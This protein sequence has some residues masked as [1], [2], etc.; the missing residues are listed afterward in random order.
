MRKV[1]VLIIPVA[2]VGFATGQLTWT[3]V[4]T[5]GFGDVNNII[6]H[7]M[8]VYDGNLYTGTENWITGTE[9]WRYKNTTWTQVNA[10]GFGDV[11]NVGTDSMAVYYGDLYAGIRNWTTGI[12]VW[13]YNGRG[14][15]R[16]SLSSPV[17]G[18]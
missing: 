15:P 4:N 13:K 18:W 8:A 16:M 7:S 12:E 5:D 6:S 9:I 14:C 10:D 3:Q 2:M 1:V 17:R 11:N